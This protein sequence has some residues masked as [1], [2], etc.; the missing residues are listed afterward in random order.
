ML[1]VPDADAIAVCPTYNEWEWGWEASQ[2]NH[3]E[4][5]RPLIAPYVDRMI[6][7]AGGVDAI[8]ER[9]ATRDVV[10]LAGELDVLWNGD[11][12][13][14]MQGDCRLRR[15]ENFFKSLREIYGRQ[16]H[17]R[18]VVS[19]VHHDHCLMFQSPEGRFAL[20]GDHSA[21]KF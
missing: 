13:A 15:S 5:G 12:E 7:A 3:R 2:A 8:V 9:Y 10:Y 1:R 14:R 20:F 21:V 16:V 17:R 19:G 4:G 6:A 18:F 11:C